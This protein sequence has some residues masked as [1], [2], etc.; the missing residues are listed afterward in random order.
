VAGSQS[1]ILLF[2]CVLPVVLISMQSQPGI[3]PDWD[4]C[5]GCHEDPNLSTAG[6]ALPELAMLK[7]SHPGGPRPRCF[8]CHE[9][10][11]LDT[12]RLDWRHPVRPVGAH[13][14]CTACHQAVAHGVGT[15]PPQPTGDYESEGCFT[16][17]PEVEMELTA[18]N[19][20]GRSG[21]ATCRGCHPPHAPLMAALPYDLLGTDQLDYWGGSF[22]P[23]LSN[24]QCLKCHPLSSVTAG[25]DSGFVTLNTINYH[26]LHIERGRVMCVECHSPH[27]SDRQ[28]M[29]REFLPDGQIF[30][31]TELIDGASC[32]LRCHDVNHDTWRYINEIF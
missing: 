10:T 7:V 2:A 23:W 20:H 1:L 29:L 16:C 24:Q 15:A 5:L 18:L 8:D 11:E 6:N 27:G 32:S 31:F 25:L 13:L 30:S 9:N 17:H 3:Q 21:Q 19:A 14:P 28:A 12:A 26:H 22:D 4:N